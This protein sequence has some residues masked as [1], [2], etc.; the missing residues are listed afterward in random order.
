MEPCYTWLFVPGIFQV[1]QCFQGL[2]LWCSV[3]PRFTAFCGG[4]IFCRTDVYY[5]LFIRASA[6]EHLGCLYYWYLDIV[7]NVVMNICVQ[8]FVNMFLFSWGYT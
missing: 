5:V 6:D 3:Y 4:I 8:V 1:T 7:G 2:F